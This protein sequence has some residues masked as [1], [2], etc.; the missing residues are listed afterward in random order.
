MQE[1]EM[2]TGGARV[3]VG[4]ILLFGSIAECC[5]TENKHTSIETL[6]LII[7]TFCG[8][9]LLYWSYKTPRL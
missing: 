7:I 5:F 4:F 8:L 2:K 9:G 3:L 6:T 1:L